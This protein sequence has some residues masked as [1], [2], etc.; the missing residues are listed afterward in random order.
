MRA[1]NKNKNFFLPLLCAGNET[2]SRQK[3]KEFVGFQ[4]CHEHHKYD[5]INNIECGIENK[6]NARNL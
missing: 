3:H 2:K 5:S 1:I 4:N 6:R